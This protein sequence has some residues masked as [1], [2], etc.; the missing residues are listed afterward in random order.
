MVTENATGN[1]ARFNQVV[2]EYAKAPAVTRDRMYIDT[3]QQIFSST[4]KVM[5]DAKT[6][7]NLLYLPLDKLIGSRSGPVMQ[8]PQARRSGP[9]QHRP[10]PLRS[11][12]SGAATGSEP[13]R[14]ARPPARRS[15]QP[16][17]LTRQG[18]PLMNRAVTIFVVGL[19]LP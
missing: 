15:A 10:A 14:N 18:E 16:R 17:F 13:A 4:S 6:G 9:P 2:A 3:M 5:I 19:P 12:S 1:A 8:A 7:S 11:R